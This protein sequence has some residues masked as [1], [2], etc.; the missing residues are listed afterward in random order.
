MR[1]RAQFAKGVAHRSENHIKLGNRLLLAKRREFP[2]HHS[3]DNGAGQISIAERLQDLF[4]GGNRAKRSL[5][6]ALTRMRGLLE[7]TI[8]PITAAQSVCAF[9]RRFKTVF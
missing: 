5:L 1:E 3:Q 7:R 9:S 4:N 8:R 2:P 6:H